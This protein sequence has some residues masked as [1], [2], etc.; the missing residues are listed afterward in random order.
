MER[1]RASRAGSAFIAVRIESIA[2]RKPVAG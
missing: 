2:D 1:G